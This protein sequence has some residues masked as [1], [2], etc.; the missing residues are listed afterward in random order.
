MMFPIVVATKKFSRDELAYWLEKHNI[1]TRPFYGLLSQPVYR[2]IF[3][4]IE[5]RYPVARWARKNGFFIGCHTELQKKDIDH[6]IA[7]FRAFFKR[8]GING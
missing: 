3:G 8:R 4:D 7:T 2:R 5:R 6:S 1:E